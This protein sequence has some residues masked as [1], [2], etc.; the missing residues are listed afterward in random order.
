MKYVFI[1][2][3]PG[4]GN[5]TVYT[6]SEKSNHFLPKSGGSIHGMQAVGAIGFINDAVPKSP[7]PPVYMLGL[8]LTYALPLFIG[9]F[10]GGGTA[11]AQKHN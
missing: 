6:Q 1:T 3:I 11:G 4:N 5:R 9:H 2:A 7:G 10:E 8:L